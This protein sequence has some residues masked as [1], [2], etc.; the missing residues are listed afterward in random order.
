MSEQTTLLGGTGPACSARPAEIGAD[1]ATNSDT[2]VRSVRTATRTFGHVPPGGV[3]VFRRVEQRVVA[4]RAFVVGSSLHVR[5]QSAV[6][7][8]TQGLSTSTCAGGAASRQR[9][10]RKPL[11]PS[12]NCRSRAMIS[13]ASSLPEPSLAPRPAGTAGR[14]NATF[15]RLSSSAQRLLRDFQKSPCSNRSSACGL[16]EHLAPQLLPRLRKKGEHC[17]RIY[18]RTK[19]KNRFL[20]SSPRRSTRI[21]SCITLDSHPSS[22][23]VAAAYRALRHVTFPN[24]KPAQNFP[25]SAAWPMPVSER[26]WNQSRIRRRR[27]LGCH[28]RQSSKTEWTA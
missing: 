9:H 2:R 17:C 12:P 14:L 23:G 13:V 24:S 16:G 21:I 4:V 7:G 8:T 19:K 3:G 10:E 1:D 15:S 11:P 26:T 27:V 22:S 28:A 6:T 18:S 20:V 25:S 5:T